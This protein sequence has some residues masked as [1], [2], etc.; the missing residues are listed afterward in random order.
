MSSS[1][2]FEFQPSAGDTRPLSVTQ[3][4]RLIGEILPFIFFVAAFVFSATVLDDIVGAPP[5]IALLL[6][7]GVVLLVTGYTAFLRTRDLLSGRAVVRDDLLVGSRRAGVR[8]PG[9]M[10]CYGEFEKLGKLRIRNNAYVQRPVNQRYR[11]V[12]SPVSKIVWAL[13]DV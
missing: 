13:E 11:V 8:G 9:R 10:R 3:R 6:F 5:P 7:L 1:P 12:Y 2:P 4:V